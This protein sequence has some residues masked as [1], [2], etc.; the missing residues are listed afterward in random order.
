MATPWPQRWAWPS[1]IRE[2]VTCLSTFL[3]DV[4]HLI[5]HTGSQSRPADIVSDII[6]GSLTFVLKMQHTPDLS[7]IRDALNLVQT[8]AR[9]TAENTVQALDEIKN[10]LKNAAA[11]VQRSAK[12]IQHNG[13]T[14]EEAR[15]AARKAIQVGRAT[16]EMAREIRNKS[17]QE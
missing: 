5:R 11:I 14:A 1:P 16:L 4:L 8:E 3:H 17:P 6:R 2:H 7:A 13:D 12:N 10:E 15:A 9:S